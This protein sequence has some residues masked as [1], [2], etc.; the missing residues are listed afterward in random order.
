MGFYA[1]IIYADYGDCMNDMKT[2][3]YDSFQE[4]DERGQSIVREFRKRGKYAEYVVREH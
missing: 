4:A 1:I 3:D 2:C